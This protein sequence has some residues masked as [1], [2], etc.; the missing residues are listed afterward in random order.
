VKFKGTA[1]NNIINGTSQDDVFNM[2]QGGEDTV[3]GGAGNDVFKFGSTLDS[4]E[5]ING[6][7]GDDVLQ[8]S[9]QAYASPTSL[10]VG[11]INVEKIVVAAGASYFLDSVDQNVAAGQTMKV[12]GSA[13]DASD[14]LTFFGLEETNGRFVMTGGAG[15]DTLEGGTGNDVLAGGT[16]NDDLEGREGHN[17]ISGGDGNDE[18]GIATA[19]GVDDAN[20]GSGNDL[21]FVLGKLTA[22]SKLDGGSG[23]DILSITNG[24]A[25]VL[26]CNDTTIVNIEK[27]QFGGGNVDFST[28]DGN[29]AAGATL[30]VDAFNL[31]GTEKLVFDGSAETN[32]SFKVF[33]GPGDNKLIGGAKNDMLSGSDGND[34]LKGGGGDDVLNGYNG[35]DTMTGGAGHDRFSYLLSSGAQQSTGVNHDI[36]TDFNAAEDTL[37]FPFMVSTIDHIVKTGALD[38]GNFNN[39]LAAAIG[40]HQLLGPG[41]AVLFKPSS[42][43]FMGHEFLIV[44]ANGEAG[45]QKGADYVIQVD[46]LAGTL[47]AANFVSIFG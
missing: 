25:N 2:I 14:T 5:R 30:E 21:F 11:L 36:I 20:A 47:T 37:N 39:D 19:T 7:T 41:H 23:D 1:G 34:V 46:H 4:G 29:V 40:P 15:N 16:G 13:L 33:G 42:G 6:G 28:A 44:D 10:P 24:T 45:Y 22:A 9:G 3:F 26:H 27:V 12:D 31:T 8:L 17:T 32:G 43:S 38:A 18:I 35:Q